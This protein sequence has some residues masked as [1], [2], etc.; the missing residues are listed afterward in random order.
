MHREDENTTKNGEFVCSFD[1]WL[2]P[3]IQKERT[4]KIENITKTKEKT[5]KR[6]NK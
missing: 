3:E 2:P 1:H 5:K 6:K 4:N